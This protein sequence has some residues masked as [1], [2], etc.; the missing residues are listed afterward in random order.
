MNI[1]SPLLSSPL[2]SPRLPIL[3]SSLS[4]TAPGA[5][6]SR[7]HPDFCPEGFVYAFTQMRQN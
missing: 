7:V 4:T 3:S 5:V 2:S 1:L 6:P